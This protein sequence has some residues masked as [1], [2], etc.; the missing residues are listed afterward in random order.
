MRERGKN[1]V[2]IKD[3]EFVYFTQLAGHDFTKDIT[4][5]SQEII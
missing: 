2:N 1:V 5:H 4:E 3:V